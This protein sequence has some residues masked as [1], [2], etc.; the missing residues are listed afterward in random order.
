MEDLI[1]ALWTF[2][3][4][5]GDSTIG[6]MLVEQVNKMLPLL[7]KFAKEIDVHTEDLRVLTNAALAFRMQP[8]VVPTSIKP[9]P[10]GVTLRPR[11]HRQYAFGYSRFKATTMESEF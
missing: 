7:S 11:H 4:I 3:T 2:V 1:K 6:F 10:R 9:F 8:R 5:K